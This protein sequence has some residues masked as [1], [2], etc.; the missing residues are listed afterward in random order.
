MMNPSSNYRRSSQWKNKVGDT[1]CTD[2]LMSSSNWSFDDWKWSE[3]L[4]T[5]SVV[6]FEVALAVVGTA[7]TDPFSCYWQVD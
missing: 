3:L 1:R 6:E 5:T 7:G 4:A 2:C